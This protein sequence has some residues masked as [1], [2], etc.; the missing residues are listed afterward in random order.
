MTPEASTPPN[1]PGRPS[2]RRARLIAT[3][4]IVA[5]LATVLYVVMRSKNETGP[6]APDKPV[7]ST[8]SDVGFADV[9]PDVGITFRMRFLERE[10][11]E[12][13]KINL[14]D[15]GCGVAIADYDGD[16]DDDVYFTNQLGPN[17]LYRNDGHGHFTDVTRSAG[18]LGLD[19]RICVSASFGDVD[20]D[21][22]Q[23][24]Y[25]TSTR[26]GNAFFRNQGDG[27]FEEETAA[28]GLTLVAH[29]EQP[30]FFDADGDGKL[31]LLVTNTAKWTT[32]E[33]DPVARYYVGQ[34]T[35]FEMMDDPI[36]ENLFYRGR[37]DGT[38]VDATA[39][40]GLQGFG[41]SGDA[42]VFDADDDGDLDVLI[43]N[44]FG[45]TELF[46]NDGKG[47]FV[48]A[49][50][51]T[52]G[53][54]SWGAMGVKAIDFDGDGR[55]DVFMTDMHSDMW[56]FPN[57]NPASANHARRYD[58]PLGS[59]SAADIAAD[60]A[61]TEFRS[62]LKYRPEEM[63][64]GNTLFHNLGG[65]RFDEV[66]Q[67]AGAE[68]LWPWGVAVG[69]FDG[70]G[71]ADA[72]IPSGMGFPYTFCPSAFL[73]NDGTG[74][75]ANRAAEAGVEV[76]RGGKFLD[77]RIGGRVAAKSSR[78][79]AAADLDGDGRLDLVVSNFN[80]RPYV[81]MN[82]WKPRNW[83]ELRLKGTT[84]NRDAIGALVTLEAGGRK[85]VRQVDAAG[86]YLAQ[87]SKTLHF[88]LASATSIDRCEIRWPSGIVQRL[89]GL[90][91][92]CRHDVIEPAR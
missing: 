52:L 43:A 6:S 70:D 34:R 1:A 2:G 35:L 16:G 78:S 26:G 4:V 15:H 36:E 92:N 68:T 37:G 30:T 7:A 3:S 83:V 49:L 5:T 69:D 28:A 31:D 66:S 33:F 8:G 84:S 40:S 48:P 14:Y 47:R 32:G 60:A 56:M 86:G 22:D 65:G 57:F 27:T 74:R 54:M 19:D 73:E 10:Q 18:G 63:V 58:S 17:A 29:S 39:E 24:L 80:D 45:K 55:L 79:V 44:M 41:W 13:F 77:E 62:R 59:F 12:K 64:F 85:I 75:F 87:S 88:G 76:P 71:D 21:G 91:P 25:V 23:D 46:R 42:A 50:R 82:R 51:Q 90:A 38:F 11:G 53:K 9:A 61:L 20:N 67:A 81:Y 89:E 72:F